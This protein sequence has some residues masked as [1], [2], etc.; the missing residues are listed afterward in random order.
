V[1]RYF[2][3][4]RL[5][6]LFLMHLLVGPILVRAQTTPT[7]TRIQLKPGGP[8]VIVEGDVE[9]D[10][11]ALFVFQATAGLKFSGHL[12]TKGGKA[13]FEV[14]DADGKGLPEEEFD[15]NTNLTGTLQKAGDYKI[16]VATFD[17][18]RVHFTLTMR[19][20]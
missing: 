9:R 2:F 7:P 15:F 3:M 1:T 18:R 14:D 5:S 16:A 4:W 12:T 13:G 20:Y 17:T 6:P 11:E 8:V 10:K 19:V